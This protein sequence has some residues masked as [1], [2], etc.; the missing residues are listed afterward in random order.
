M[1]T[2]YTTVVMLVSA[3]LKP[4][5]MFFTFQGWLYEA[6]HTQPIIKLI[7]ACYMAR[8]EKNLVLEEETYRM[9]QEIMRSPELFKAITG[10]NLKGPC[11]PILDKMSDE[12]KKKLKHLE[13][14]EQKGFEVTDLKKEIMKDVEVNADLLK[15]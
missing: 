12:K 14:L 7:E 15:D 3:T 6:T 10:T 11:D 13:K 8:H 4:V 9:L 1:Q 5:C 2:F